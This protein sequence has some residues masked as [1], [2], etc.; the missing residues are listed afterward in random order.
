MRS[1]NE[2]EGLRNRAD[3]IDFLPAQGYIGPIGLSLKR[4]AS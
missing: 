1:M 2:F 3:S 4:R